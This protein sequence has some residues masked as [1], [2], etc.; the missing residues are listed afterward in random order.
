MDW[1]TQWECVGAGPDVP[2]SA[3]AAG[4]RGAA[5][6]AGNACT[7]AGGRCEMLQDGF[8]LLSGERLGGASYS[9]WFHSVPQPVKQMRGRWKKMPR[10]AGYMHPRPA[11]P[12]HAHPHH[13]THHYHHPSPGM[14]V[15]LGLLI[16][17]MLRRVLPR[18][19]A[20]PLSAW[21]A[22]RT[23]SKAHLA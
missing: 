21:H 18:L 9:G 4:G 20:S 13:T 15:C 12:T 3:C 19:E 5:T 7:A 16:L 1:L 17:L 23:P 2:A 14:G 8:Y 11:A 10:W 6:A 22:V